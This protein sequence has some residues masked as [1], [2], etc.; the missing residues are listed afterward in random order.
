M[1]AINGQAAVNQTG[2]WV[3]PTPPNPAPIWC[4]AWLMTARAGADGTRPAII[5]ALR[6]YASG[7]GATRNISVFCSDQNGAQSRSGTFQVGA[8]SGSQDLGWRAVS[9]GFRNAAGGDFQVGMFTDG[10]TRPGKA[11]AGG[12]TVFPGST[13]YFQNATLAGEYDYHQVATAPGFHEIRPSADGKSV[14]FNLA[15]A[16]DHGGT[17]VSGYYLQWAWD[18]GF[19]Q[20][21]GSRISGPSVFSLEGMEPGRKYFY[22]VCARNYISDWAGMAGGEWS[23]THNATQPSPA[24]FGKIFNGTS[25]VDNQAKVWNGTSFVDPVLKVWNGTAFVDNP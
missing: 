24:K 10:S 18:A 23:A 19:T 4:W 15:G 1:V 3:N 2:G 13:S 21:V 25:F 12:R 11:P 9:A 7:Y 20:G 6:L 16:A 22:R 14:Y 5:T 17:A 8:G